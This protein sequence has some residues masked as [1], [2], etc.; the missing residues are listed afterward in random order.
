VSNPPLSLSISMDQGAVDSEDESEDVTVGVGADRGAGAGR[1]SGAEGVAPGS[2]LQDGVGGGTTMVLSP[3]P[4]FGGGGAPIGLAGRSIGALQFEHVTSVP[5]VFV[6]HVGHCMALTSPC[7][8][9]VRHR[10]GWTGGLGWTPRKTQGS[11]QST[12]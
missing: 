2:V 9:F 4:K 11:R 5:G 8:R 7:R 1:G 3:K 10:R 6:P 12:G